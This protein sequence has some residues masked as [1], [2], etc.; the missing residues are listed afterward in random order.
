MC[1]C[2]VGCR[3]ILCTCSCMSMWC[4]C[5][6]HVVC[7]WYACGVHVRVYNSC[8]LQTEQHSSLGLMLFCLENATYFTPS[9]S[10]SYHPPI[11]VKTTP[12]RLL[13]SYPQL[14]LTLHITN[15]N[16]HLLPAVL[17]VKTTPNRLPALVL[18]M[19]S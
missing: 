5:G 19:T 14:Y 9:N 11:P 15:H 13:R 16:N 12:N 2:Y 8:I 3:C 1:T 10:M 7:M 4:T 18:G 17:T 6:V